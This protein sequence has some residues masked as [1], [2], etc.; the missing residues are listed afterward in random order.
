MGT[1][2]EAYLQMKESKMDEEISKPS[3]S[4][5]AHLLTNYINTNFKEILKFSIK[6][7]FFLNQKYKLNIFTNYF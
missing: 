2:H 3:T 6:I 5:S 7:F 1:I 4:S